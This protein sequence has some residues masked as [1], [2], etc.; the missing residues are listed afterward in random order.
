ML[1]C[2]ETLK[3]DQLSTVKFMFNMSFGLWRFGDHPILVS[4][5][6]PCPLDPNKGRPCFSVLPLAAH[7]THRY[8][9]RFWLFGKITNN[10]QAVP[11][12]FLP[13]QCLFP[14]RDR[15]V[16]NQEVGVTICYVVSACGI[17]TLLF[18]FSGVAEPFGPLWTLMDGLTWVAYPLSGPLDSA[19]VYLK[20]A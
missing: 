9:P 6:T 12:Q 16:G 3:Y 2:A 1:K 14:S 19:L 15:P 5:D 17:V 8:V 13:G 4:Y 10:F 20:Q 11:F 7:Q 18:G